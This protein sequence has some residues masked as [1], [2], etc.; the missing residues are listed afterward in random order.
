MQSNLGDSCMRNAYYVQCSG[1]VVC[2]ECA[3]VTPLCHLCR[4]R[5]SQPDS[6]VAG[7]QDAVA[8]GCLL[9]SLWRYHVWYV[10]CLEG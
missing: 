9:A 6:Y 4:L 8:S 2:T 5:L 3:T 7:V 10:H 1:Y